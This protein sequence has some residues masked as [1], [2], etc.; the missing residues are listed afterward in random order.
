MRVMIHQFIKDEIS[1]IVVPFDKISET[2]YL[3]HKNN[4]TVEMDL[5]ERHFYIIEVEDYIIHPYNGFTLH[6]N[7]NHGVVP[8][9][10]EMKCEVVKIMGKMIYVEAQGMNDGLI[11]AGW[12][13]KK[14]IKKF[15][16][17]V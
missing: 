7:W 3:I 13:P 12:L 9:D 15:Q 8:T 2:E 14:S 17:V 1:K 4:S 11:W 16:V 5:E 6:E 10:K